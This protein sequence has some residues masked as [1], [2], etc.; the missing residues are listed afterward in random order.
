MKQVGKRLLSLLLALCM[1]MS[2]C[3]SALA[4]NDVTVTATLDTPT[5]YRKSVAQTVKLR[6]ATSEPITICDYQVKLKL[7]EGWTVTAMEN[8]DANAQLVPADY[9]LATGSVVWNGDGEDHSVTNFVIYTVEIPADTKAGRYELSLYEVEANATY[10]TKPVLTS[11]DNNTSATLTIKDDDTSNLYKDYCVAFYTGGGS[12]QSTLQ[13]GTDKNVVSLEVLIQNGIINKGQTYNA[14]G[15]T[16]SYDPT[17]LEFVKVGNVD[18]I[19][20]V[21]NDKVNGTVTVYRSGTQLSCSARDGFFA[22]FKGIATGSCNVAI[23]RAYV[24]KGENANVRN[25]PS[26]NI[27]T[28]GYIVNVDGP[29][30]NVT[31][32]SPQELVYEPYA[33]ANTAYTFTLANGYDWRGMAIR[34]TID[35]GDGISWPVEYDTTKNCYTIPANWVTGD[36]HI[37]VSFR[38]FDVTV[39]G[40][41]KNDVTLSSTSKPSYRVDYPFTLNKQEGWTYTV[42]VTVGGK[43]ANYTV[44]E[45]GKTY[46]IA[47]KDI[48]GNIVIT[49]NKAKGD[50][51]ISFSGDT[52]DLEGEAIR[53]APVGEDFTFTIKK[54]AN[55]DYTVDAKYTESGKTIP[56]TEDPEGTYTI[57]GE[58]ITGD[59][60]TITITKT[61]KWKWTVEVSEYVK[62]GKAQ[63]VFLITA[64]LN[65][66]VTLDAGS[67]LAY[68]DELMYRNEAQYKDAYREA[69]GSTVCASKSYTVYYAQAG[70][71]IIVAKRVSD[72][73]PLNELATVTDG[74]LTF[75]ASM[76]QDGN[77]YP[78]QSVTLNGRTLTG[79]GD[80]Y[81]ASLNSG[82]NTIRIKGSYQSSSAKEKY[83][84]TYNANAF[85]IKTSISDTVIDDNRAQSSASFEKVTVDSERYRFGLQLIQSTG[86]ESIDRVRVSDSTGT[87]S[88]T[89]DSDG[90]YTVQMGREDR[91]LYIDY[92]DSA[93]RSKTYKY[94]LHFQRGAEDTPEDR[95]PTISPEIEMDGTIIG[96]TDGL[97]LKNPDIILLVD[98]HS[99]TGKQL[100]SNN[101]TVSVNGMV[102]P[103]PVSQS[104]SKFGYST[105]LSNEGANTITV[106]ATDADGYSA[107][108]SW[109]VYYENGDITVTVSVEATT[110]GL[111]YLVYPTEV[112]VPGGTDAWSIVEKVLTENGFGISG[113]GSYLSAIQRSGICSGFFIDP[114]LMDLIV[115]DGM[116]ENGARLDPQPY[117]MDSLGEFDFYRWSGWMYSYNGSYPGYGMNVCKPQDGS[118]IRVRYTLALGKDIGGFTSASGSYGVS[119]GNYYKEW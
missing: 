107:T 108:R 53:N 54:D 73:K 23:T 67:T 70:E 44:S 71:L 42:A 48:I 69:D 78:V 112:T 115:A 82:E 118:V 49:A 9:N 93:G 13:M 55:Y 18:C 43:N 31:A 103:A 101:Y 72:N 85:R 51:Q 114:E 3:V 59:A 74:E 109:T 61:A 80:T 83:T 37:D 75:T 84:I 22:E 26:A 63:S 27:T 45:D 15:I 98:G 81:T 33:K 65:D 116:D 47:G 110:V 28:T 17:I 46:T 8:D 113:S 14:Y 64:K 41:A 86:K 68:G 94:Q 50:S 119:S 29:Y 10:G 25:A 20:S 2:L 39:E 87:T 102:V 5:L 19:Y 35:N 7:P 96:L 111:G 56:V 105:Y 117:S 52:S 92:K 91:M 6:V 12:G 11:P 60:I 24:D 62:V 34:Y 100:Y 32:S 40:N 88:L 97:T 21:E 79:I 89:Q 77:E 16:L 76:V 104:G 57:K 99:Y 95:Q 4:V 66:G 30:Y 36:I 90:W 106:T 58:Y 38:N 1:M